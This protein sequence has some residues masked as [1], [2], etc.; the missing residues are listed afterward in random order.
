MP[1]LPEVETIMRGLV[2]HLKNAMIDHVIIRCAQLRWPIPCDLNNI[3]STQKVVKLSRRGKY[4]LIRVPTGTLILHLGM[5]GTL[6]LL[7]HMI[8]P[9]S[10][11]HM[12]IVFSNDMVLR[13]N[14]PRRFGAILWTE[15]SP[16][17][18][19]LLK[20]MGLEPLDTEFTG[21]YLKQLSLKRHTPI[22]SFIMNSKIVAGIGNIYAAE[23]LFVAGLH[24]ATP[25][26]LL[27]IEQC[28]RLVKSIK[29]ILKHAIAEGGTTLKDF[30]N[31]A[32]K[33]G[34]FSQ[35][36]NVYGRAG[37][38]CMMCDTS[39]QSMQLGQRSTVFCK[40]CQPL[41]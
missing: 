18:H 17:E 38:P 40:K 31:S 15:A 37:L 2:P 34:Y 13:Y 25:T 5:S 20:C 3:L 36:L 23:A 30:V 21:Q 29:I 27:S 7:N 26:H 19:H 9:T 41:K 35:K 10:H 8:P 28:N 11:D 1:E 12:D 32:G 6:K 39:L 16:L 24:P 4:L 33:P 14:D 22:K